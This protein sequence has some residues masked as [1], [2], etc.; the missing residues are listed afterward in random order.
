MFTQI[1]TMFTQYF[2]EC[3]PF[4]LTFTTWFSKSWHRLNEPHNILYN[5]SK[6]LILFSALRK[7][8]LTTSSIWGG[9]WREKRDSFTNYDCYFFVVCKIMSQYKRLQRQTMW[10]LWWPEVDVRFTPETLSRGRQ[11]FG[12]LTCISVNTQGLSSHVN[13]VLFFSLSFR[14]WCRCS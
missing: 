4:L 11:S 8:N 10:H 14:K 1:I 7:K 2:K 13:W 12:I 9:K 3:Q 6:L 5:V